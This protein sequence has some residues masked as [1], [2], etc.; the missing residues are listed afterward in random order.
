VTERECW[1]GAARFVLC[2]KWQLTLKSTCF[3]PSIIVYWPIF[4]NYWLVKSL[5][6]PNDRKRFNSIVF[7]ASLVHVFGFVFM[8]AVFWSVLTI[9]I[10]A[11]A[12]LAHSL[13]FASIELSRFKRLR[14]YRF[15]L[16]SFKTSVKYD[17]LASVPR[18][19]VFV[20]VLILTFFFFFF[21]CL[22]V[23]LFFC[24][25]RLYLYFVSLLQNLK[26]IVYDIFI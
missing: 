19:S 6:L 24:A 14:I 8:F 23:F 16:N 26:S 13:C 25:T 7:N 2:I 22:A 21:F 11:R 3:A 20:F 17:W 5:R 4:S 10:H 12:T 1:R 15:A 18:V 9:S